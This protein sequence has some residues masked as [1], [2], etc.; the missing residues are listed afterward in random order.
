M[1]FLVPH[2]PTSRWLPSEEELSCSQRGIRTALEQAHLPDSL[3][4]DLLQFTAI[5]R[6]RHALVVADEETAKT[7]K[8]SHIVVQKAR[9]A[10]IGIA[11]VR[12]TATL[13]SKPRLRWLRGVAAQRRRLADR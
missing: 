3:F 9:L 13:V 5:E 1:P 12:D 4:E 2:Q 8:P 10:S 6:E 7:K 11:K